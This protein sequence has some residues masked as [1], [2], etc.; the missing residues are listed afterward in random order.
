MLKKISFK[1]TGLM[2]PQAVNR[3]II[4]HEI[5]KISAEEFYG[6]LFQYVFSYAEG[7]TYPDDYELVFE[8]VNNYDHYLSL[9]IRKSRNSNKLFYKF[10]ETINQISEKLNTVLSVT[11]NQFLYYLE[12]VLNIKITSDEVIK[13]FDA[14][15]NALYNIDCNKNDS[16]QFSI[17]DIVNITYEDSHISIYAGSALERKIK[18]LGF[19]L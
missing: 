6:C 11:D 12:Y 5:P 9:E 13:I 7:K 4:D 3:F 18:K 8:I 1:E 16:I 2:L 15:I 17:K 10:H 19:E 14:A